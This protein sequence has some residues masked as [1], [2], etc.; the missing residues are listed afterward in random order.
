MTRATKQKKMKKEE[1]NEAE[2][3]IR[4]LYLAPV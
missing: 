4:D 3:E 2:P 1:K